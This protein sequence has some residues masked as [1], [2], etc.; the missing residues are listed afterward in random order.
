M[1][2][3]GVCSTLTPADP[4][5]KVEPLDEGS[6][7]A[8]PEVVAEPLEVDSPAII[9]DCPARCCK[10]DRDEIEVDSPC[11]CKPD[12]DDKE[13]DSPCCCKPDCVVIL[14]DVEL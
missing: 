11:C 2:C 5:A 3:F 4:A 13:V 12:R 7:I 1:P 9:G 10:P 8:K 14:T 6:P